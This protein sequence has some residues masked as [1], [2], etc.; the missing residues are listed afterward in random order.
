MRSD[1]RKEKHFIFTQIDKIDT[2]KDIAITAY[3]K[4]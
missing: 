1:T 3:T 4:D 2:L